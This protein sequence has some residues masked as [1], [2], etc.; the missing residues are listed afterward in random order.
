MKAEEEKRFATPKAKKEEKA[1]LE[2]EKMERKRKAAKKRIAKEKADRV[3]NKGKKPKPAAE[4]KRAAPEPAKPVTPE[5]DSDTLKRV[6]G[7]G[8]TDEERAEHA[9]ELAKEEAKRMAMPIEEKKRRAQK[10]LDKLNAKMNKKNKKKK[11]KKKKGKKGKKHDE[12]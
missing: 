4:N 3:A 9:A 6:R 8:I 2:L 12:M 7:I 5:E 1:R 10:E 11:K